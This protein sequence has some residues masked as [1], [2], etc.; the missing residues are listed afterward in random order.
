ML[1]RT[2]AVYQSVLAERGLLAGASA[3]ASVGGIADHTLT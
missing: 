2:D 3:P 1:A